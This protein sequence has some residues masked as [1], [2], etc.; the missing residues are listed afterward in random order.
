MPTGY[1]ITLMF[2]A[3]GTALALWP[4]SRP[5]LLGRW[6]FPL[7]TVI[8]ELPQVAFLLL[9][10][11]TLLA[12]GEDGL[13]DTAGGWALAGVAGLTTLGLA[14]LLRRG[15]AARGVVATAMAEGLGADWRDALVQAPASG[16]R[17][18]AWLRVLFVPYPFRPRRV[19]RIPNLSY[20]D[21]GKRNRLD[22][23][24]HRSHPQ[25]APTLLYFHGGGYFSGNKNREGRVLLHRLAGR[26][27]VCVSATYRLRPAVGFPDHLVDA[28]KA[29]AWVRGHGHEYGAD[30]T[31]LV[32]AG[33]SAG[34]HLTS[35]AALTP[36][37]P[38]L[39]PG[40]NADTAVDAAI[41]LYGYYGRYYGRGGD[42]RPPSTPL[43]Y[44]ASQAPPFFVAHGDCDTYVPVEDARMLVEHL[45]A[46]SSEPVIY[47]EL[48]GGQHAFDQ[49][50]SARNEAVVDAIE[51]F[52]ESHRSQLSGEP[53]RALGRPAA[54]H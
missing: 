42:E 2:V 51:A 17:P 9:L 36:N 19:E 6:S 11:S 20:G 12:I 53:S 10:A 29:I 44:N 22:V 35:L 3:S 14:V 7:I 48:P 21:A 24:R 15:L 37:D 38:V 45:R 49:F 32:V 26:G 33:S 27:W 25:G 28:K 39:Q 50:H 34:A 46:A 30:P 43:A 52:L 5:R 23:Y 54:P 8:N 18:G 13:L 47:A 31:N 16:L 41:C 4:M 1:L 40:F